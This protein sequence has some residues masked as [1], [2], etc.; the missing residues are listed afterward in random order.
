[1]TSSAWPGALAFDTASGQNRVKSV[2]PESPQIGILL[3]ISA[4]CGAFRV[5]EMHHTPGPEA[6]KHG[7][8]GFSMKC[9]LISYSKLR[10]RCRQAIDETVGLELAQL[11]PEYF[12]GHPSYRS[13]EFAKSERTG[14]QAVEN[15]RLPSTFYDPNRCVQRASVPFMVA[16]SGLFHCFSKRTG[17]FKV[18]S[19]SDFSKPGTL[20]YA[21]SSTLSRYCSGFQH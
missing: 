6:L 19:C 10:S 7:S 4:T 9:Q 17:Y 13:T 11:L 3:R 8:K 1:V 16:R 21:L 12:G 2:E 14:S 5:R 18:L 20:K 15:H